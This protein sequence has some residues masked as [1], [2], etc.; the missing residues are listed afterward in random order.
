MNDQFMQMMQQPKRISTSVQ[1]IN[2]HV[3]KLWDDIGFPNE[4]QEEIDLIETASEHDVIVIDL[5]T[6]GGVLDSAMLF[7]RALRSTAAHTVA[8]IGPSCSSAGSVIALSCKE[9]V[10]DETS[11]LMLHT[12]TYGLGRSKDTDIYEHANFSRKHLRSFYEQVYLGFISEIELSDV[13]NGLPL[14][15]DAEQLE[16]RLSN[17][18]SYREQLLEDCECEDCQDP[19]NQPFNILDVVEERVEAGIQKALDKILK[20]HDLVAKPEKPKR[21]VKATKTPVDARTDAE[22]YEIG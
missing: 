6:D 19:N 4:Y 22:K 2:T 18:Q 14:Y 16:E 12:S 9:F 13:I 10:L 8:V 3:I 7:N 11:S 20:K 17:L 15:F 21:P 1:Q 5:C